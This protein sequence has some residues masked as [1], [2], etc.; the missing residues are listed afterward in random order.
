MCFCLC[1]CCTFNANP[2][3]RIPCLV[4]QGEKL[5]IH[6]MN[7]NV[8]R[9]ERKE[10]WRPGNVKR[11]LIM[12]RRKFQL[13]HDKCKQGILCWFSRTSTRTFPLTLYGCS[14]GDGRSETYRRQCKKGNSKQR[15]ER[16][17]NFPLPRLR[18]HVTVSYC[19]LSKGNNDK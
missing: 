8:S 12:D 2:L 19:K 15:T 17:Y 16:R 9:S 11:V 14:F 1:C 6:L 5:V 7:Q 3:P 4:G 13:A 18:N 10:L